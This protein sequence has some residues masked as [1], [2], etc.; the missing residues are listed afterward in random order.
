[1][2]VSPGMEIEYSIADVLVT[3]HISLH[4]IAIY[5]S[6]SFV[7]FYCLRKLTQC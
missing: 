1:M 7:F 4:G 5:A 2:Y 3:E 6:P